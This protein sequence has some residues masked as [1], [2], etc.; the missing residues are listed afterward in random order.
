VTLV[1]ATGR[2]EPE[3]FIRHLNGR[4]N[5]AGELSSLRR[6]DEHAVRS[7]KD[8]SVWE[9]YHE[10]LHVTREYDHEHPAH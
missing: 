5:Q 7:E 2:M 3:N 6:I 4:H 9:A 8:R 1:R 10:R